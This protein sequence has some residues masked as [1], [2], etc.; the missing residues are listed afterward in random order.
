M[1]LRRSNPLPDLKI[2]KRGRKLTIIFQKPARR[3]LN[4][5]LILLMLLI[6]FFS[7]LSIPELRIKVLEMLIS[8]MA[9]LLAF[10]FVRD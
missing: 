9:N 5:L 7:A 4:T 8:A 6:C 1:A 10:F 2:E 3:Q